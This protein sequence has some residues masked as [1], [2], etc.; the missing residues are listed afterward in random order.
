MVPIVRNVNPKL[1][2]LQFAEFGLAMRG[3]QS[4]EEDN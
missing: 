4:G 3:D 2:G 1:G